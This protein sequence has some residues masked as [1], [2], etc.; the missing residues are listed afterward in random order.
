MCGIAGI[1]SLDGRPVPAGAVEAMNASLAHRGP[2]DA[3]LFAQDGVGL[4]MRRLAIIGVDN[5]R[6]PVRSEDG[7][8][9]LVMNGEIYNYRDLRTALLSKGHRFATE[10]D[11]EAAVHLY[12]ERGADFVKQL[13]GM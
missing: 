8:F 7:R 2:D 11:V 13:R 9:I 5:G 12:E 4:A 6:Q 1:V 3:G 10:S